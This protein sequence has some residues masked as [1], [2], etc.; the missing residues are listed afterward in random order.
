MNVTPV[1]PLQGAGVGTS[2]TIAD[3]AVAT[4]LPLSLRPRWLRSLRMA[5]H[6]ILT[7]RCWQLRWMWAISGP[8]GTDEV[9]LPRIPKIPKPSS[10]VTQELL[11]M[12][13]F[14]HD[15]TLFKCEPTQASAG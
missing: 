15:R 5:L 12:G 2:V 1:Q 10:N 9:T 11:M 6:G 13:H 7:M 3:G 4:T 8:Y 14:L